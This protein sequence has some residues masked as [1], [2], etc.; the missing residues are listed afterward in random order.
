MK[1]MMGGTCTYWENG[2]KSFTPIFVS[3]NAMMAS[4]ASVTG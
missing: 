1:N 3:M 4:M 2:K